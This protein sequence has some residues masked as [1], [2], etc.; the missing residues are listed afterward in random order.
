MKTAQ[1]FP[2]SCHALFFKSQLKSIFSTC[3]LWR[4]QVSLILPFSESIKSLYSLSQINLHLII[5]CCF[6][7]ALYLFSI[8]SSCLQTNTYVIFLKNIIWHISS[9]TTMLS[10]M[11]NSTYGS[12]NRFSQKIFIKQLLLTGTMDI[13]ENKI[14]GSWHQGVYRLIKKTWLNK[15]TA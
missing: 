10:I 2:L 3:A 5:C 7:S 14:Q 9:P 15:A 11:L 4:P 13:M 12:I 8:K 1:H 6:Y